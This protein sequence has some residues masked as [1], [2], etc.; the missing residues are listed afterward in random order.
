MSQLLNVPNNPHREKALS[1][2]PTALT[3]L[4]ITKLT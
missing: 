2:K 4:R 3:K 1:N